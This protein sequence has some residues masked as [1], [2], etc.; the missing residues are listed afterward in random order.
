[1]SAMSP[2]AGPEP[3]HA[4][5]KSALADFRFDRWPI[6]TLFGVGLL[7]GTFYGWQ[8]GHTGSADDLTRLGAKNLTLMIERGEWW[9]LLSAN[10]LHASFW[11]MSVNA[12]FL[13]NLGGP[14]ETVF[15]RLD[16]VL[17]LVLS[18]LGTSFVSTLLGADTSCGASGVVFGI[19]GALAMFGLKHRAELPTRYR[20]YFLGSVLP[21][22]A[23]AFYMSWKTPGADGWG[24]LGGLATGAWL[25][26]MLPP[27]LGTL[28]L[29]R[30]RSKVLVLASLAVALGANV[31]LP[32]RSTQGLE[33]RDLRVDGLTLPVPKRWK[34]EAELRNPEWDSVGLANGAGVSLSIMDQKRAPTSDV[35]ALVQWLVETELPTSLTAVGARVT[36]IE[37]IVEFET[38]GVPARRLDIDTVGGSVDT[39]TSFFLLVADDRE[40]VMGF[41]APTW[42]FPAYAPVR[43]RLQ[44]GLRKSTTR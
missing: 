41:S 29:R 26:L 33:M 24:H 37:P 43:D 39:T 15:R 35:A 28:A 34:V 23:V 42:L 7:V 19:W 44:A 16:Y 25:G 14:A 1:M 36:R 17:L 30:A 3:P 11:H 13:F 20:R 40:Y 22:A 21:Y 10:L 5:A 18:A 4:A 9:R 32:R 6:V 8:R 27:R 12:L 2:N 38:D 31:I